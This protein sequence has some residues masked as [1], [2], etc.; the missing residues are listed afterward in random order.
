MR[1]IEKRSVCGGEKEMSA[2]DRRAESLRGSVCGRGGFA[3][4]HTR[5]LRI[6][7]RLTV[8]VIGGEEGWRETAANL[9]CLSGHIHAPTRDYFPWTHY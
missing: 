7:G 2:G 3:C 8:C 9:A 4:I 1:Q 6:D 5:F